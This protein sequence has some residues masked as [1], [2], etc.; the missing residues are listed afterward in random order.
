LALSLRAFVKFR[1]GNWEAAYAS[2]VEATRLADDTGHRTS[3]P[4]S[5]AALALVEAGRGLG[6]ARVHAETAIEAAIEMG[7]QIDEAHAH[8]ALGLLDLGLGNLDDAIDELTRCGLI[9]R[10]NNIRHIGH[11]QWAPQLVEAH[12]RSRSPHRAE[13]VMRFVI[14]QSEVIKIPIARAFAARCQGLL[15][16]DAAY[17]EHFHTA[18][19]WHR[20]G[21]PRP[22]ELAR[23]Q[24]CFGERLRRSK[25]RRDARVQ[26]QEAWKTFTRL[27]AHP[28]AE[29]AAAELGATGI[30]VSS[31]TPHLLDLLTPREL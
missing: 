9:A 29:R 28:W 26:L 18:L 5:T 15:T 2:A 8:G 19:H 12:V 13:P 16:A 24:L 27:G 17:Q 30:T 21:S 10:R 7:A 4:T 11:L 1:R 3:I 14:E 6:D 22:F 20:Q 31:D 25:H 23:T